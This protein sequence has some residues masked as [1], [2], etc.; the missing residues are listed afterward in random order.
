MK[1][2]TANVPADLVDKIA[3]VEGL[4]RAA[5]ESRLVFQRR[6]LMLYDISMG[7]TTYIATRKPTPVGEVVLDA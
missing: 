5:D 6:C 4:V 7:R 2:L 3:R 1:T